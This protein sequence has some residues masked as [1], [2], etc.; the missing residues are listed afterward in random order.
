M[1]VTSYVSIYILSQAIIQGLATPE[2]AVVPAKDANHSQP[3][4]IK[5]HRESVPVK[6]KGKVVSFKTSYAGLINV[7]SSAQQ[8]SVVFD[9]GSGH[10]VLPS[11]ECV[12]ESCLAHQ[13]YNMHA[14]KDAVALNADSNPVPENELCDQL[15]IAYGTGEVTGEFVRDR[16]CLGPATGDR[17]EQPCTEMHLVMAVEMSPQP[18]KNFKFDGIIGLG[19]SSLAISPEFSFFDALTRGSLGHSNLVVPHF[20]VFLAGDDSEIAIGGHNPLRLAEPLSW[21]PVASP[22]LGYWQLD[23]VAVRV[24]GLELDVCKDGGCR[25]VVDTG[26]SHLGI[27][28]PYDVEMGSLLSRPATDLDNCRLVDAPT[29][30]FELSH[31]FK[32]TLHPED[33]M[34]RLPLRDDM[35]ISSGKGVTRKSEEVKVEAEKQA[36]VSAPIGSGKTGSSTNAGSG[37]SCRPKIVPVNMPAPLGPKLFILGEPLLQRYYTTFDWG[38]RRV[39]FGRAAHA[40]VTDDGLPSEAAETLLI[41]RGLNMRRGG[42]AIRDGSTEES[43]IANFDYDSDSDDESLYLLQVTLLVHT[44]RF[45]AATRP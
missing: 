26:T 34:R 19:L 5:L 7:G 6:R 1:A 32:L 10:V 44:R 37:L 33:Y 17:S 45:P 18:F 28:S 2:V 14:S 30:E 25:G 42:Q 38:K 11:A 27:P 9:T 3:V 15:T 16:V 12:S 13:T 36:S 31:G 23:I 39:G 35:V 29:L 4:L 20:G 24:G 8:F 41:Q 21:V 43:Q 22:E 40:Q